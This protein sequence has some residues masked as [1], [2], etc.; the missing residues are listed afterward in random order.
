[1]DTFDKNE[2]SRLIIASLDGVITSEQLSRLDQLL[3]QNHDA[4][5]YYGLYLRIYSTFVECAGMIFDNDNVVKD[6]RSDEIWKELVEYEKTAP[7]IR[8]SEPEPQ[9]EL[10]QKVLYPSREKRKMSHFNKFVLAACAAVILFFVYLRFTPQQYTIEV[11]TL[12]DQI[13]V[14]WS[15]SAIS[16]QNGDRLLTSQ[17]PIGLEKGIVKIR[18][19]DG[20]EAVI[21]APAFFVLERRGI[22]LEYGRLYSRVS[23]TGL[24][25]RVE[26]P[27]SQFIDQGTEFGVQADIGGSAQM[28][29]VKGKVQLFAGSKNEKKLDQTVTANSAV[30]YNPNV[31]KIKSIPFEKHLFVSEIDSKTKAVIRGYAN[32]YEAA[33]A[34]TKPVAWYR[35]EKGQNALGYDEISETVTSCDF[36][37]PVAFA[38]GPAIDSEHGNQS[39]CLSGNAA[40]GIFLSDKAVQRSGGKA[41]TISLWIRP[42]PGADGEQNVICFTDHQKQTSILKTNQIYLTKDNRVVFYV[43]NLINTQISIP[44]KGWTDE[45]RKKARTDT[46][47]SLESLPLNQWSHVAACFSDTKIELYLNGQLSGAGSIPVRTECHEG[48]YWG[49]GCMTGPADGPRAVGDPRYLNYKGGIDEISFYD[50]MLTAQEVQSLYDAAIPLQ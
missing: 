2:L 38:A 30:F 5:K 18:Y 1:M 22:Y 40:S 20:V 48:G 16:F 32:R 42:Q 45:G 14:K 6:I 23:E 50:R 24:G 28:Q 35:F 37:E 26:T 25:F 34:E 44:F 31:H 49:I 36:T 9:R 19:D 39:L 41:L 27:N 4:V 7:A 29:V 46:L 10:I 43:Y 12:I 33:V 11:A 15:N 21:E 13:D 47:M 3:S 8:L 17:Q